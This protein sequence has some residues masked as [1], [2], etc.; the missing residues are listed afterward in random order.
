[1]THLSPSQP[2]ALGGEVRGVQTWVSRDLQNSPCS[3]CTTSSTAYPD[4]IAPHY[5]CSPH[6][7]APHQQMYTDTSALCDPSAALHCTASAVA[8]SHLSSL[9]WLCDCPLPPPRRGKKENHGIWTTRFRLGKSSCGWDQIGEF[10]RMITPPS[11]KQ[12]Q[13]RAQPPDCK[14]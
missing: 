3:R 2:S 9:P 14:D 13:L 1:M 8:A 12:N 10:S 7:T 5:S 6:L 11:H 4:S